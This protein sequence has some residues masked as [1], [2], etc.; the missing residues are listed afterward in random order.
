MED[1]LDRQV[2]V[3]PRELVGVGGRAKFLSSDIERSINRF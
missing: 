2:K 3:S 1:W